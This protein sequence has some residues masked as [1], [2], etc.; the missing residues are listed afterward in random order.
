MIAEGGRKEA[1][2]EQGA[3]A[4]LGGRTEE[5]EHCALW[6]LAQLVFFQSN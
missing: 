2:K 4:T 3:A 1:K 6:A 5:V